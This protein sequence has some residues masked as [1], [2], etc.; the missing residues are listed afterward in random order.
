MP[1]VDLLKLLLEF[2]G[3]SLIALAGAHAV[4]PRLFKWKDDLEK[5]T[6]INKQIFIAH[7]L[8]IV[9]GIAMLGLVCLIFPMDLLQRSQLGLLASGSFFMCWLSRLLF[10]FCF[11]TAKL[12]DNKQQEFLMRVAGTLLWSFYTIVFGMSFLYQ[13]RI[14]GG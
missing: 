2:A 5:L 6:P 14:I 9:I 1:L 11:F 12:T 10:Q 7:T 13:L 4:L 8:F 3:I